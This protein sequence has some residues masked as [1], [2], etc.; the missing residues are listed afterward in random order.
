MDPKAKNAVTVSVNF[1]CFDDV[2]K[3]GLVDILKKQFGDIYQESPEEGYNVSLCIP[4]D[5]LDDA[6]KK[7]YLE[8]VPLLKRY[9]MMGP[10]IAAFDKWES[11]AKFEPIH[12]NYRE[13]E[14]IYIVNEKDAFVVIF[15]LRFRD[16]DDVILAQVF[17]QEF[18][19]ARRDK[20]VGNA[21]AVTFTQGKKPLEL[22]KVASVKESPDVGF[23]SLG[24]FKS[25]VT[26]N[27]RIRTIDNLLM[28]RNYF[29]YHLKC[30]KA[31]MHFR[32]RDRVEK[33]LK[34][35]NRAKIE[36]VTTKKAMKTSSGRFFIREDK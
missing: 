27:N 29:H 15:S 35:L 30:S 11:N 21:P 5:G 7:Q 24:L 12:L 23:V 36:D 25:H 31:Y 8:E 26:A 33:S 20:T 1:R 3:F 10:F 19:D 4:L 18:Q 34:V 13:G 9:I 16:P 6:K 2:S 28:F 22:Q 14:S 17:L 32:M